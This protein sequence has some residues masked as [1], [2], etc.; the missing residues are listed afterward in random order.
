LMPAPETGRSDVP[1]RGESAGRTKALSER[2]VIML[3]HERSGSHFVADM[4]KSSAKLVSV[5][6]VCNFNAVDPYKSKL[7]FFRF[8]HECQQKNP[9]FAYRPDY[10]N[11]TAFCDSYFAHLLSSTKVERVLVDIKY[12]HV[13]NFEIGWWPSESR[14]F[15][16]RYLESRNVRIVHLVRRDPVAATVSNFVAKQTGVWHRHSKTAHTQFGKFS[17]PTQKIVH[18]ALAL[19][20]ENDNFFGWLS[21]NRCSRVAYEDFGSESRRTDTMN[22]LFAFLDLALQS[23]YPTSLV[24]VTPPLEDV[25]ENYEDLQRTIALFG[26]GRLGKSAGA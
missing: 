13:H 26:Q 8:R 19:Q 5:D 17:V 22:A 18:E 12:G 6:E 9:E 16:A 14:P 1:G 2:L 25:V 3:S 21:T 4:L 15:L 20:R 24:K 10:D 11:L 7:S 23:A